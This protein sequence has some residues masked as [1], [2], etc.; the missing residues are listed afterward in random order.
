MSP[1]TFV[2]VVEN[3]RNLSI[4]L[5]LEAIVALAKLRFLKKKQR[6]SKTALIKRES[7]RT[8]DRIT[9]DRTTCDRILLNR[10]VPQA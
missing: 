5:D 9:R 6:E 4:I 1:N 2:L 7:T 10:L 3:G 8:D